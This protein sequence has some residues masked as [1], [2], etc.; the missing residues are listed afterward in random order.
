MSKPPLVRRQIVLAI[1][2]A[3]IVAAIVFRWIAYR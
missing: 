3:L 2:A 1:G